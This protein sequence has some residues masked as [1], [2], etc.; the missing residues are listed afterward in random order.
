MKLRFSL[1]SLLII[2]ALIAIAC[3]W[4]VK[5]RTWISQ[6]HAILKQSFVYGDQVVRPLFAEPIA[7]GGLWVF[8]ERGQHTLRVSTDLASKSQIIEL[9]N[10]FPESTIWLRDGSFGQK[11]SGDIDLAPGKYPQ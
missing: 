9:R 3:G 8:G 6:R 4:A 10:L 2:V 1:K 5:S 7:P 11:G